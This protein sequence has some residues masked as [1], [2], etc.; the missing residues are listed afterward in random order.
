MRNKLF[1]NWG[2]KLTALFIA[3][4]LWYVFKYLENPPGEAV[5]TDIRVEF[6]NTDILQ[7]QNLVSEVLEDTDYIARLNVRGLRQTLDE[8]KSVGAT[9]TA[10]ADYR[11]LTEDNTIPIEFSVASRFAGNISSIDTPGDEPAVVKLAIEELKTRSNI[12]VRGLTT[13]EVK[14]SYQVTDVQTDVNTISVTGAASKVDEIS[15]A[16]VTQDVTGADT[17]IIASGSVILYDKEGNQLNSTNLQRSLYTT[18]ITVKIS[19]TKEVPIEYQVFGEPAEGYQTAGEAH[20]T[21]ESIKVAGSSS[22]LSNLK[23]IVVGGAGS[24]LDITGDVATRVVNMN[25]RGFLPSGVQLARDAGDSITTVTVPIEAEADVRYRIPAENI[26]IINV[27][28][29]LTLEETDEN[30]TYIL[31][32]RGIPS[33]TRQLDASSFTGVVD[34]AAW[35]E[36]EEITELL[37]GTYLVPVEMRQTWPDTV[38]Q[39]QILEISITLSEAEQ[40][41]L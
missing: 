3:F 13:G 24:Q 22:V 21:L 11:K 9:I 8:M 17:D 29:N 1:S 30:Q 23:S 12:R 28:E 20:G 5:F 16:A 26:R 7:E 38:S 40:E 39:T 25:V 2:L 34:L 31:I 33:V 41:D 18:G 4:G 10:I 6:V 15:Y 27:P 32:L 35:A 37:P 19:A 36:E 14:E